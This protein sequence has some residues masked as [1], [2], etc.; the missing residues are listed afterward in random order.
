MIKAA[1]LGKPIGHSLSPLVHGNIYRILGLEYEY[2]RIELDEVSAKE[3]LLRELSR[4]WNGFSLTMPLKEVGLDLGLPID[5][6]AI[7]AHAVNTITSDGAFNT[8][9][10]G[11]ARVLRSDG[12]SFSEVVIIGNGATA[13]SSLLG[14]ELL[15]FEGRI[16]IVRRNPSKDQ[17]LPQI[18]EC[19]I[20]KYSFEE[21]WSSNLVDDCL[22][23]STIPSSAQKEI[24]QILLEFEGSLLDFTYSPWPSTLAGVVS[25]RVISGLPIL[26][27]Q[28]IDQATYFTGMEFDKDE[29]FSEVLSSTAAFL[30]AH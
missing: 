8:D 25:G 15:G 18:F 26:V 17:L 24:S 21:E 19:H 6:L 28:A 1:V 12:C 30:S 27:A 29:M 5:H 22:V 7:R 13:R 3:F 16:K 4:D 11:L 2:T 10:S 23:I 9:A 14:L 20:E